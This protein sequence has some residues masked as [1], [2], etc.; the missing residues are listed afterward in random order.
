[1]MVSIRDA[2][3]SLNMTVSAIH[4][5]IRRGRFN[6]QR[7]DG[8]WVVDVSEVERYRR[9]SRKPRR[10]DQVSVALEGVTTNAG[11]ALIRSLGHHRHDVL[12]VDDLSLRLRGMVVAIE[13][14][15]RTLAL[16]D[17]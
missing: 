4:Q 13:Q 17:R 9:E 2:A 15:A 14:E 11:A 6:A 12:V 16:R 8:S 1:M 7:V 3:T 10:L 5:A